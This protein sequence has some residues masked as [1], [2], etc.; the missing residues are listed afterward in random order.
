[1]L[2]A[3]DAGVTEGEAAL[4]GVELRS[5]DGAHHGVQLPAWRGGRNREKRGQG[6]GQ[7]QLP[8]HPGPL[9]SSESGCDGSG[10]PAQPNS[11]VHVGN[12][13]RIYNRIS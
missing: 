8:G 6:Q 7:G 5:V 3:A 9:A 12:L 13:V 4:T 11:S 1:M 10:K 2:L